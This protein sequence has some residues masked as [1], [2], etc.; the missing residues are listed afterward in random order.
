MFAY[1]LD[2]L[3]NFESWK[4]PADPELLRKLKH[5][6]NFYCL[7]DLK[8]RCK[9]K[10]K[11]MNVRF[12][13]YIGEDRISPGNLPDDLEKITME[14]FGSIVSIPANIKRILSLFSLYQNLGYEVYYS[15]IQPKVLEGY[16][17]GGTFYF[18]RLKR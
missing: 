6:A 16:E 3:R 14:T 5:E 9:K 4:P 18:W 17:K 15:V 13:V 2:Y 8:K 7:M 1:V 11:L 10:L 12:M